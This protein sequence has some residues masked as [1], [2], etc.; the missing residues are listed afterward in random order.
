M[1]GGATLDKQ[2]IISVGR[3]FGSG[4]HAIAEML[5]NDLGIKLYDRNM[6]DEIAKEK[7]VDA[8]S[9][10]SFDEKPKKHLFS[11]RVRDFSSSMEENLAQLQFEYIRKKA[12]SGESFVI[13]GRCAENVLKDRDGVISVFILGDKKEKQQRVM[14]KYN[15]NAEE[16]LLKMLRHDRNRKQYHNSYCDVRWGDSR[17]YDLCINSSR[18]GLEESKEIIKE[19]ILKRVK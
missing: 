9:F 17:G 6:L 16:A 10:D 1:Q 8:K 15:L 5:A 3:E 4:G 18:L 12:D 19:Y 2:L 14:E 7:N 13:V 11:R